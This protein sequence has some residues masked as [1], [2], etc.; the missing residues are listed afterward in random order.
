MI[1]G[2]KKI[3]NNHDGKPDDIFF[4][5]PAVGE[6]GYSDP[7]FWIPNASHLFSL[8]MPASAGGPK[9]LSP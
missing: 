7:G 9:I 8:G 3:D 5:L 6:N 2:H 4:E 1:N